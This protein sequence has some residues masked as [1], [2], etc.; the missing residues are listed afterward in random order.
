MC[1][2]CLSAVRYSI[3]A[4]SRAFRRP[5]NHQCGQK[6]ERNHQM[7]Q[8]VWVMARRCY[9][10]RRNHKTLAGHWVPRMVLSA[11]VR[12]DVTRRRH[13]SWR[14]TDRLFSCKLGAVSSWECCQVQ[15]S[16]S[17]WG[18]KFQLL[19]YLCATSCGT[20]YLKVLTVMI[21]I[22]YKQTTGV[23]LKRRGCMADKEGLANDAIQLHYGSYLMMQL[24]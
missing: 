22:N 13:P 21:N 12:H 16:L 6:H 18:P 8:R 20:A 1:S 9:K 11:Y 4:F 19:Y 14:V 17:T 23:K 15:F 24:F 2:S 5:L 10:V 7:K 3:P